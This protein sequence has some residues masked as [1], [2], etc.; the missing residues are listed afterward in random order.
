[1]ADQVPVGRTS[2]ADQTATLRVGDEAPDFTLEA[3]TGEIITLS[4]YRGKQRVVLAFHPLA[5]TR[6]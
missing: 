3:H 4:N 5:W 1:M 2:L 6:V